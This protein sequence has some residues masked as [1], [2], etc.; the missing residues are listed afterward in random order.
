M[1][2]KSLIVLG[3][4]TAAAVVAAVI[5]VAA[6]NA[7]TA[8]ESAAAGPLVPGLADRINQVTALTVAAGDK[9]VT[10]SRPNPDSPQ[11]T[12]AEKAGYPAALEQVR[13]TVLALAEARTVE[14][15]TAKPEQYAKLGVDDAGATRLTL[16]TADGKELPGL[17]I[18]KAAQSGDLYARRAGE[19]QSWLTDSRLAPPAADPMQWLD[20]PL[21][22]VARDKVKSVSIARPGAP[23]LTVGRKTADQKD[24]TVTGL[25]KDAK[26]KQSA[27]NQQASA[28]EFLSF[29]DVTKL[30]PAAKPDPAAVVATVRAFDGEVLA[31]RISQRDGKPWATFAASL[32]P[33]K[34]GDVEKTVKDIQTRYAGWSYRLP[35]YLAKDLTHSADDLTEKAEAA[36]AAPPAAA[37]A[38]AA[39]PV[40]TAAPA[41]TP[42]PAAKPAPPPVKR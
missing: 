3:G 31:I 34:T 29:E 5:A 1:N 19:P 15:R 28:A 20:R 18:G 24:F 27:V 9:T 33:G 13:R 40:P 21:P 23:L 38:A 25:P 11:W 7:A 2:Q 37:P 26:P 22:F 32:E 41:S 8:P 42:T 36:P 14:P 6:R 35:D 17:L 16:R 30:D 4:V 39:P 10:I 12:V